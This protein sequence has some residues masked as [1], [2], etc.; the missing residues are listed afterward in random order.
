MNNWDKKTIIFV[1]CLW[2][3]GFFIGALIMA[4]WLQAHNSL[5][6]KGL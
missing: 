3:Q 6:L 1:I 4:L 2:L 5:P